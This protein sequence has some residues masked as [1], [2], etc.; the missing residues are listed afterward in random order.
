MATLEDIMTYL[1]QKYPHKQELS[2]ARFTKMVYLADWRSAMT[3]GKQLSNIEWE[4]NHYG[5]YVEDVVNLARTSNGF[6]ITTTQNL[7]GS[8]KEVIKVTKNASS[9]TLTDVDRRILDF[10]VSQTSSLFWDDFIRLVYS[11]YPIMNY[12]KYS[13]LDLVS[14][15]KRYLNDNSKIE[16]TVHHR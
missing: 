16:T 9:E 7:F 5:P 10:V 6:E 15:A 13:K 8:K 1:Y 14:L 4:F 12:P 3:Q 11:T 2:K